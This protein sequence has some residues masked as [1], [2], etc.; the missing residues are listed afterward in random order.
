MKKIIIGLFLSV[1]TVNL[2]VAEPAPIPL[3]TRQYRVTVK[4]IHVA[5]L[6]A[7]IKEN[8]IISRI[9]SYG[10]AKKISKYWSDDTNSFIYKNGTFIPQNYYTKFNQ[11]QGQRIVS[12]KYDDKGKVNFEQVTPPDN[13]NKRP[14]VKDSNKIGALD[15]LTAFLVARLKTIEG[16]NS[17]NNAF[18]F[19]IYDGRRL[20]RL[21]FTI[22]G[23][24]TQN[25]NRKNTNV[26]SV[27]FRRTALEGFT[28]NELKRIKTEEP[29]FNLYLSDDDEFLP[30][31]ANVFSDLGV[32]VVTLDD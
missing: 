6:K 16:L 14:A 23:R 3:V 21:D 29:T 1:L 9:D 22:K 4:G 32:A 8:E 12:I 27:Q 15:P 10:L 25:I 5:D 24:E 7:T 30:L 28:N 19:N 11:R 17:G 26:I 18:S 20:F 13:R 2:A 31:K